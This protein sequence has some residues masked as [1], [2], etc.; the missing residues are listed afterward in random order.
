MIRKLDNTQLAEQI[1]G[2]W[3]ETLIWSCLQHVMGEIYVDSLEEPDR[4]S[5]V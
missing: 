5:V 4:K 3:Q 1:F 2:D